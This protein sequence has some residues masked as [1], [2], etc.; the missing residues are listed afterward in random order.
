[1][2]PGKEIQNSYTKTKQSGIQRLPGFSNGGAMNPEKEDEA[3]SEI[4]NTRTV[5]IKLT[6]M[7]VE[8]LTVSFNRYCLQLT[9]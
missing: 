4:T 7:G 2:A 6:K 1:M 3:C 8:K 5:A 9:K